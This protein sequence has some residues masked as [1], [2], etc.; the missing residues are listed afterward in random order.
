MF[1]LAVIMRF[2]YMLVYSTL[3]LRWA[4]NRGGTGLGWGGFCPAL[5]SVF[6]ALAL[7]GKILRACFSLSDKSDFM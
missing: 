4:F 1:G 3:G 5:P 2:V 7:G 6:P